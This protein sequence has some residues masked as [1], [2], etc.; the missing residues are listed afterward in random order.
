MADLNERKFRYEGWRVVGASGVSLF[1]ASFVI[2]TF[3]VFLKPLA[4]EF[5]WTRETISSAFSLMAGTAAIASPFAG[6]V[7]DRTRIQRIVVLCMAIAGLGFASLALLTPRVVQFYGTFALI[8]VAGAGL[9][10]VSYSRAISTWFLQ[11][12]GMALGIVIGGSAVAGIVQ[13]PLAQALVDLAGWRATYLIVGLAML[14]I[15]CPVAAT[16]IRERPAGAAAAATAPS[17]ATIGEGLRSRV[18]WTLVL[19]FFASSIALNGAI[20]HLSALLT[21]RG[22]A[23]AEAALALSTMGAASL[24]GRLLT[25]WLLDRFFGARVSFV[26]LSIAALGTYLLASAN[27]F[28]SGAFAAAL[29]GF[30]MG[31]ELDVTPYLLSRY[32]GLRSFSSLYGLAFGS[33]ALAGAVGP[34]LLG[35]AFD[36]T[37]SYEVVLPKIALFMIAASV[38]M[39]TLPRYDNA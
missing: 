26:M 2:Y 14:V 31:G 39:L 8:G 5:S 9:S 23:S 10:P 29:I 21:D 34:I 15:G 33:S 17:G 19:V 3:P 35:R 1:F 13:P 12:R 32:L 18:L 11:H 27:S 36:A 25:G 37:G 24:F 22:V 38:F 20:V 6:Y 28:T 7:L 4:V 30:G 16:L